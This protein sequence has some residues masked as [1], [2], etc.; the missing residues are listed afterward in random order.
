MLLQPK[1]FSETTVSKLSLSGLLNRVNLTDLD[2]NAMK[3]N[4]DQIVTGVCLL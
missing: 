3:L 2:R 4:G 1:F